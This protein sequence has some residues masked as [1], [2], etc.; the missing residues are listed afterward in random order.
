MA[1]D[2]AA[3]GK[4]G[5]LTHA[6]YDNWWNGGNRTTPQRHNIVGRADR[7]GEREAGHADL[8]RART[9]CA[10]TTRGFA[11]HQPA[12]NF[13]DP[14]PG[15]WWRLRD[16]VDYELICARSLLT[17]AARYRDQFQANLAAMARD[18]IDEGEG[19]APVRLGRPG[20]PARPGHGRR[21]GPHPPRDGHRGPAGARRRSRPPASTY[22]AGTWILPAA[23][24]Y[25]AHLKD[26]MERQVYPA[27]ARPPTARP[28]RPTTSP[29]GRSRCRWA[30]APSTVAEPFD[31][32]DR[33]ARAR[34]SRSGA[35]STATSRTAKFFAIANQAN[36]DFIVLNALLE[37]GR[38]GRPA[39]PDCDE[40][41]A[42]R[43]DALG[44]RP[45]RGRG[46]CSTGSCRRSRPGS[47]PSSAAIGDGSRESTRASR[48][49]GSALYQP[50]VPSMDEG[51]TRLVLE[52]FGF[53]YTTLHNADIRAGS[54]KER[55]DTLLIPSIEPKTL[56]DGYA[57]NETEPAYVGGLGQ[58]RGRRAPRVP[59]GRAG[60][61]S[62][63][64]TRPS[65]RSRSWTCPSRTSSRG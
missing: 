47:R 60:R 13:V 18:A 20:R 28:S 34:S 33:A 43:R 61:S 7:G 22:P 30:S 45:T 8:P 16:I 12:V 35:G 65:T 63:W 24:P 58:R 64:R 49:A 57:E 26:M 48:R 37:A 55:I 36:D 32:D 31:G 1:S 23:Q 42:R 38:R 4:R 56:R 54:L 59:P 9:T 21:D 19:R 39:R 14:W 44:S 52:K 27:A 40:P 51:W 29:A 25:R 50:W 10:A 46:G 53:P 15:G 17:L 3:A 41:I 11:D 62:A 2:L 6:M 5:V